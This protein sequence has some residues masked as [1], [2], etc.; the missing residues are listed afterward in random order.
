[1][2]ADRWTELAAAA[3]FVASS[4]VANAGAT[5]QSIPVDLDV[6]FAPTAVD[7]EGQRHLLYELHI[8]NAGGD[9]LVLQKIEILDGQSGAVL[10]VYAGDELAGVL[11]RPGTSGLPD[12][13]IIGAGLRAVAFIDLVAPSAVRPPASVVN[14]L[15]FEPLTPADASGVQTV[16]QTAGLVPSVRAPVMLGPPLRGGLWLASH[17][18]SNASSHRR[19]LITLNG[20]MRISQRF[21]IDWTRIGTDGQVFRGDPA[22]N[23]NWTP[24]GA[25]VL[26][27]ADGRVLDLQDGLAQN[28]PTADTKAIPITFETAGGNYLI[29]DIGSGRFVFYAHL[30]PGSFRARLGDPVKQGQVLARLGNSGKSDAPHLHLQ[31]MDANSPLAAEGLPFVFDSF[32]LQ[33]HVPSLKVLVDGTGWRPSG[34]PSQRRREMPV[35]NAVIQFPDR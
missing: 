19:T 30:Q 31:V 28:D 12:R 3:I 35:E 6:P 29:L 33:G 1:V 16:V 24:Y 34:P 15:T 22:K 10:M 21:A 4:C 20:K 18:L 13:R 11:A 26:A 7:A 25:E 5:I 23:G 2:K 27:V 8:T 32:E 14:R 17:G 9:A